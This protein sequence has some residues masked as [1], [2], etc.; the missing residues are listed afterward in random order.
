[1]LQSAAHHLTLLDRWIIKDHIIHALLQMASAPSDPVLAQAM[2]NFNYVHRTITSFIQ[3]ET[4]LP[5]QEV[6][7]DSANV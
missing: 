5:N 6:V 7:K 3:G 2:S 1:M 4:A